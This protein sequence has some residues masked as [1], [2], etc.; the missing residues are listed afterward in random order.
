MLTVFWDSQGVLLAYFLKRGESVTATSYCN[1][2]SSY[3]NI[4]RKRTSLLTRVILFHYDNARLHTARLPQEKTEA[5]WGQLVKHPPYSLD[6]APSDYHLFSP[7]RLHSSGM[8]FMTESDVEHE[9]QFSMIL[10]LFFP[11]PLR[12]LQINLGKGKVATANLPKEAKT[13]KID[14]I[15]VQEPY[16]KD[17]K[18]L[19]IRKS[20]KQWL[21]ANGTAGIISLPSANAP[22]F[23]GTK[24]NAVAIKIQTSIGP[25]SIISGYSSPYSDIQYTIQYISQFITSLTQESVL[26]GADMNAHSTLWGYPN[27]SPRGNAMEDFIS[28]TNLHL[29]N[30]KDAGP[31]FQTTQR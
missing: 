18:I 31:T 25:L 13:H 20:W 4:R 16:S 9:H 1:I 15:L 14:L 17:G 27:D 12:I 29:L 30:V 28:S 21:S 8:R 5:F 23:L 10:L 2:L 3:C 19:G 26:I 11:D 7:H 24:E 22:I 6:L